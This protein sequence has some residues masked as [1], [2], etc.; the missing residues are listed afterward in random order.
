MRE[1]EK[2]EDIARKRD[3]V[4]T[5]KEREERER[6]KENEGLREMKGRDSGREF[7]AGRFFC[8]CVCVFGGFHGVWIQ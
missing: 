3:A 5:E 6:G 2:G 7:V 1:N 8:V 4:E